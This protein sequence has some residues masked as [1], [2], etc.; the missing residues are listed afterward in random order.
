[1]TVK[2]TILMIAFCA[3]F[4]ILSGLYLKFR[5]P[6]VPEDSDEATY[7]PKPISRWFWIVPLSLFVL[8]CVVF[9][10]EFLR[11]ELIFYQILTNVFM[12]IWI[13]TVGYIDLRER[14]IPN[15]MILV[16]F[17]W[18]ILMTLFDIFYY[19]YTWNSC[20]IFSLIG[21]GFCGGVLLII[22]LI[23]KSALGMGDV[24]MF[25][26]LGLIYGLSITYSILLF[27][28]VIMA[29]VSIIL[30]IAKKVTRKTSIPVAPFSILG[31]LIC[32]LAGI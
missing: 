24:K 12:C 16:A 17:G 20:L 11:T 5:K 29:I 8:S 13:G 7:E 3:F 27:T 25:T 1:M 14:I 18:W 28:M 32:I 21:A 10:Y 22:A 31:F 4:S 26:V 9:T 23:A 19:H 2:D 30:L 6:Y 15:F